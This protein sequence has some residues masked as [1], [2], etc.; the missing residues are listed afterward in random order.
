MAF[1][2]GVGIRVEKVQVRG[3]VGRADASHQSDPHRHTIQL[4]S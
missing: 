2:K 3:R 4:M 1:E